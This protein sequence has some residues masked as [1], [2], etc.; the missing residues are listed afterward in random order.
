[1]ASHL[2]LRFRVGSVWASL[3]PGSLLRRCRNNPPMLEMLEERT[4]LAGLQILSGH[5]AGSVANAAA[6]WSASGDTYLNQF[7]FSFDPALTVDGEVTGVTYPQTSVVSI[8]QGSGTTGPNQSA[9]IA[10]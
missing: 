2:A 3:P 9:S 5:L 8:A 7:D 1:V 6:S 4:L 10:G